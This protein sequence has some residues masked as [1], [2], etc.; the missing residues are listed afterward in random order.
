CKMNTKQNNCECDNEYHTMDMQ[1]KSEKSDCCKIKIYEINNSNTLKKHNISFETDNSFQ[2][3][4]YILPPD[5]LSN[6]YLNYKF[7][8][9]FNKPI[10][11][12]PILFSALLI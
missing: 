4:T 9:N 12:I 7:Y 1:I 5:I 6:T 10:T 8:T 11:D 3:I 2:L